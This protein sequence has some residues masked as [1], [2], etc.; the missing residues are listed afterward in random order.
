MGRP[1]FLRCPIGSAAAAWGTRNEA[2]T[3]APSSGKGVAAPLR[4]TAKQ[5]ETMRRHRPGRGVRDK[6]GGEGRLAIRRGDGGRAGSRSRRQVMEMGE[7][8]G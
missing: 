1:H 2:S 5:G 4:V 3:C 8:A 6:P 7:G